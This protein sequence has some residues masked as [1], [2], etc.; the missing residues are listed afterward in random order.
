MTLRDC[1]QSKKELE[2]Y[3]DLDVICEHAENE[4]QYFKTKSNQLFMIIHDHGRQRQ[5][6]KQQQWLHKASRDAYLSFFKTDGEVLYAPY[7]HK[8]GINEQVNDNEPIVHQQIEAQMDLM[9][10][11]SELRNQLA[12]SPCDLRRKLYLG[13]KQF[14]KLIHSAH[15]QDIQTEVLQKV[16]LVRRA[17]SFVLQEKTE[18]IENS[19]GSMN[20]KLAFFSLRASLDTNSYL[21]YLKQTISIDSTSHDSELI[22]RLKTALTY[23]KRRIKRDTDAIWTHINLYISQHPEIDQTKTRELFK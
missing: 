16:E 22:Q 14:D 7:R 17:L 2:G 15:T 9:R 3:P 21:E 18:D 12:L 8:F 20:V 10:H 1:Y 19:L 23:V 11:E 6:K 13:A 4:E 5:R